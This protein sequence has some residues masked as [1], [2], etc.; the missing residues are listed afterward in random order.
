MNDNKST[1]LSPCYMMIIL[2]YLI[3]KSRLIVNADG[4]FIYL[5]TGGGEFVKYL[6][7]T[8][9]G[10]GVGSGDLDGGFGVFFELLLYQGGELLL[11]DDLPTE[12]KGAV[13]ADFQQDAAVVA[14]FPGEVVGAGDIQIQDA[15]LALEFGV[16]DEEDEQDG[17]DVQH[18]DDAD[19]HG[20]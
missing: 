5:E 10:G 18:G 3:V 12:G 13:G 19:S 15:D 14:F 16:D 17:E 8:T 4:D 11:S 1:D 6:Q 7:E 20:G 2:S 9:E